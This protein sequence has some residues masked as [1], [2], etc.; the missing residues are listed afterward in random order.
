MIY[1]RMKAEFMLTASNEAQYSWNCVRGW[2]SKDLA[3]V[4]WHSGEGKE[5]DAFSSSGGFVAWV[6]TALEVSV[7]PTMLRRISTQLDLLI[8]LN[9]ERCGSPRILYCSFSPIFRDTFPQPE[10]IV[11]QLSTFTRAEIKRVT[12]LPIHTNNLA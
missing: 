11:L 5:G 10:F 3:F 6:Y 12:S 2:G 8:N 9:V 4:P 7:F 1:L